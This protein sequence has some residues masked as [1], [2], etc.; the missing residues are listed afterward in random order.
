MYPLMV[1]ELFFPL[2]LLL[3]KCTLKALLVTVN[4]HVCHQGILGHELVATH[5]Q[6]THYHYVGGKCGVDKDVA[7]GLSHTDKFIIR[8]PILCWLNMH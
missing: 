8:G 7:G 6:A 2:E 4:L 1:F 3:A 5:L